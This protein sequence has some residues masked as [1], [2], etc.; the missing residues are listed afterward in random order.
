M[1]EIKIIDPYKVSKDECPMVVF[2][3]HTS[4]LIE[5]AIKWRTKAEYNHTMWMI[6]PGEFVSQ[7]NTYST[8]SADRYMRKG[9]RL[10]F[11]EV[12]GLTEEQKAYIEE[13]INKKLAFP[14]YRKMYDWI[15]I[16][17][18]AIGIHSLNVNGLNYCSEDVQVHLRAIGPCL[19]GDEELCGIINAVP[20]H[21]SPQGL[22]EY[23]LKFPKYFRIAGIW[24]SKFHA[25]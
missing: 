11:V 12:I 13:S 3:D 16:V 10:L 15:G 21:P 22:L 23:L 6:S 17:G 7:G 20:K 2:S 5:W 4:G 19:E 8:V 14:W 18:Q 9:N 24:E 1:S 25:K